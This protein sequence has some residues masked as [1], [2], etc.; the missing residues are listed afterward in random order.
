M[1]IK[2]D[3]AAQELRMAAAQSGEKVIFNNGID[4]HALMAA[5]LNNMTIEDFTNQPKDWIK[6]ERQKAKASNFGFLYGMGAKKFVI[7]AEN[8]YG[9]EL[10]EKEAEIIKN[11]FW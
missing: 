6:S 5:K 3:F 9:I 7:L 11:K 8:N 1:F 4:L 10:I 2:A